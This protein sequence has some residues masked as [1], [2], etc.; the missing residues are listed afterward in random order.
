MQTE[1]GGGCVQVVAEFLRTV[2]NVCM[3]EDYKKNFVLRVEKC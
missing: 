1:L 2:L 3:T